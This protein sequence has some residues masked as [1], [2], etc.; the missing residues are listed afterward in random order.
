[1]SKIKWFLEWK[2]GDSSG[3]NLIPETNQPHLSGTVYSLIFSVGVRS[4]SKN[5]FIDTVFATPHPQI[6]F[7][8]IFWLNM[9]QRLIDVIETINNYGQKT[10]L[11]LF[12]LGGY[13]IDT[14]LH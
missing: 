14:C 5:R 12:R 9:P 10:G 1:M 7:K 11:T 3:S 2:F 8:V 4:E 13:Q 6:I